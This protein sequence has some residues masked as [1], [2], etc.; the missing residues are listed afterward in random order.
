[1]RIT[2]KQMREPRVDAAGAQPIRVVYP[3]CFGLG[4]SNAELTWA[5]DGNF[6]AS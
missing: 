4:P 3:R 5:V 2:D 1:M 6:V